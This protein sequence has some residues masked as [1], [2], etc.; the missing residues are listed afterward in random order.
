MF[1]LPGVVVGGGG[2]RHEGKGVSKQERLEI[3]FLLPG[4]NTHE[5]LFHALL[6]FEPIPS[7]ASVC[8]PCP[9]VHL[10]LDYF[11]DVFRSVEVEGG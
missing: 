6:L 7:A 1:S 4:I 11:R 9:R 10:S 5:S 3:T 2:R 8:L